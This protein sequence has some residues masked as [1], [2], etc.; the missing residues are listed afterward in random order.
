MQSSL[1]TAAASGTVSM[2]AVVFS[3]WLLSLVHI[4]VP[5]DAAAALSTLVTA[6]VHYLIAARIIPVPSPTPKG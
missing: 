6:G 4:T 5:A 3:V 1:S 2:A